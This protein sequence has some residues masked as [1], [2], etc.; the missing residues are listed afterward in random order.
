MN[1]PL[2]H[3]RSHDIQV[4]QFRI[5]TMGNQS[6]KQE[7]EDALTRDITLVGVNSTFTNIDLHD[8]RKRLYKLVNI[9]ELVSVIKNNYEYS[10]QLSRDADKNWIKQKLQENA[11]EKEISQFLR[12][13]LASKSED[14][15]LKCVYNNDK[16]EY[17]MLATSRNEDGSRKV[18]ISTCK[19]KTRPSA[20]GIIATI[21]LAAAAVVTFVATGGIAPLV[22]GGVVITGKVVADVVLVQQDLIKTAL[23]C[24]LE[25]H[26]FV[27][28]GET[29]KKITLI[30]DD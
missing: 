12:G 26:H 13:L 19:R 17:I 24:Y 16:I 7:E 1:C 3:Q 2:P 11:Q 10:Y 21:A 18:L 15:V 25:D 20:T 4:F 22:I 28:I 29:E 23:L 30:Q 6:E 9:Y 5:Q 14:C 27:K 8:Y